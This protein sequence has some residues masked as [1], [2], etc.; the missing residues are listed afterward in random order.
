VTAPPAAKSWLVEWVSNQ[1]F[2]GGLSDLD[3]LVVPANIDPSTIGQSADG[4]Y[5]ATAVNVSLSPP[6]YDAAFLELN[7]PIFV[8]SGSA[9]AVFGDD[10]A[11]L[12][13][14]VTIQVQEF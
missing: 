11:P 3:I 5:R 2:G 14:P 13:A 12:S 10:E 8:P 7:P 6:I 1:N 9:F 4:T